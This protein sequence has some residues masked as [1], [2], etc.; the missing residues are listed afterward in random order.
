MKERILY[1]ICRRQI[2]HASVS[3]YIISRRRY[4]IYS[5]F[6]T[7]KKGTLAS[8]FFYSFYFST[9]SVLPPM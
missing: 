4:I 3:E 7:I 9:I 6:A 5:G 1:H 2:Y 8:S